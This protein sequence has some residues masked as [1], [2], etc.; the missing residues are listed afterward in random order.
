MGLRT[1][2]KGSDGVSGM[3][4]TDGPGSKEKGGK[5]VCIK[6]TVLGPKVAEESELREEQDVQYQFI[7][8]RGC[9]SDVTREPI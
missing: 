4:L 8:R 1:R 6:T 7:D 3:T 9:E 5:I 2:S